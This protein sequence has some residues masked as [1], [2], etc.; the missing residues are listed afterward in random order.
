ML[1]T[2]SPLEHPRKGLS[3]RLAC[4]KHAA[5]VRPEP[6]S[7]SPTK[8]LTTNTTNKHKSTGIQSTLLSS[9]K[10]TTH[11]KQPQPRSH[12]RGTRSQFPVDFAGARP[13][14]SHPASP[15]GLP[16]QALT[17]TCERPE[18][19]LADRPMI[20]EAIHP[21]GSCPLLYSTR[22]V[23]WVQTG[24]RNPHRPVQPSDNAEGVA[25]WGASVGSRRAVPE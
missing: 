20:V 13:R 8:T 6:G 18:D 9:Q 23:S 22:S 17:T 10:T 1:L 11:R 19:D 7:N 25:P 24:F 16:A 12:P 14:G 2:R 5:S 21:P 3:A 4:V 15:G